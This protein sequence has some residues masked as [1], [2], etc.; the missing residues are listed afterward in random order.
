M[1]IKCGESNNKQADRR[2]KPINR[3]E[4][5]S[6]VPTSVHINAQDSPLTS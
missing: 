4:E 5:K 1:L 6:L 3:K 2:E